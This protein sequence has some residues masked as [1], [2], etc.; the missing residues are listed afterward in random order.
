MDFDTFIDQAW[1]DHANDPRAVAQRLT[2]GIALAADEAQIAQ[3]ANLAH[4]VHGEHL[5][6]WSRGIG[7]IKGL[8]TLPAFTPDGPSG[9]AVRRCVA[10]LALSAGAGDTLAALSM[11][12]RVRVGAM[13]A[14][15]LAERDTLRAQH[16]LQAALDEAARSGLPASDPMNRAL[17]V[18]GNN[19]AS[20]L[21]EKAARSDA[22]RSLMILAAQTA[23]HYWELA[24]TWLETERAEYRLAM[25]WLQAGDPAE[26]R[27]HAQACLA[28]IAANGGSALERLFGWEALGRVER[29]A[30]HAAGHA[31]A[32]AKARAALAEL[33]PA[34]QARCA[35]SIEQLAV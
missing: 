21:E 19:L 13:A 18:A 6:E 23:R 30:G 35:A 9:Q 16:L 27:E 31:Q 3:L 32:L 5:G 8:A 26:A 11:S 15:N 24:G 22:E 25:T 2:D 17:A 12:D 29:A 4:H 1:H 34:D 20:A 28:I 33:D 7:V 14:A 10:S